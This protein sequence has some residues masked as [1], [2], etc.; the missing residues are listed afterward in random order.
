MFV[1]RTKGLKYNLCVCVCVCA[2]VC[3]RECLCTGMYFLLYCNAYLFH[4][5]I[6]CIFAGS[7]SSFVLSRNCSQNI[8]NTFTFSVL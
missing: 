3:V 5:G 1:Y 7:K 2:C 6:P 4:T 8:C